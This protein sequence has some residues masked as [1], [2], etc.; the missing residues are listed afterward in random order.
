MSENAIALDVSSDGVA[1]LLINRP[2]KRNAFD[3]DMVAALADSCETLKGADH[4]RIVFLKGAGEHFSAGFD[5]AT[6][7]I[8]AEHDR[9]FNE[10]DALALARMLKA[11]HDLPQ[12]TVALI[13]GHAAGAALGLIAAC[14]WA[15]ATERATLRIAA[16]RLGMNPATLLPFLI[17]AIG[18][19]QTRGLLLSTAPLTAEAA[20]A[21]GLVHEIAADEAGLESAMSRLAGLA[22]ET[23]PSAVADIKDT[24]HHVAGR[25]LD[26]HLLK[27]LARKDADSR[28][29]DAGKEGV[30]AFLEKRAPKW[31]D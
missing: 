3:N 20:R 12:L 18:P 14:D 15:V 23:A 5:L 4:V 21:M 10:I 13:D 1:V 26:D 28:V 31:P 2:G 30:R 16:A 9:D 19:R 8:Q 11:L 25:K 24:V 29:S 7:A 27:D 17:E 22:F 6:L